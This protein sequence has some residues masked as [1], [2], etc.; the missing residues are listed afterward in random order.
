[1]DLFRQISLKNKI[2]FSTLAV[3]LLLSIVIALLAR[4]SLV[5]SLTDG[6]KQQGLGIAY[7]VAENC[8]RHILTENI[9]EL[10][11]LMFDARQGEESLLIAYVFVVDKENRVLAHSMVT[12]LPNQLPAAN[13][14]AAESF[15]SIKALKIHAATV[16]DIAVPVKEGIYR[17]GT[18]HVGLQKSHID[19]LIGRLR[20]TF[21]GFIAGITILFFWISHL[22][23][24][25]VTRPILQLVRV[26]DEISRGNPDIAPDTDC[27]IRPRFAGD[28]VIQLAN[29]FT[30]MTARL[31]HTEA[32]IRRSEDK[33]RSLFNSGPNPIFVL[34]KET[35]KILDA[36]PNA[37]EFYGYSKSELRD[38]VFS[39]LGT[40]DH[41]RINQMA[42]GDT[43]G[44]IDCVVM[45]KERH[46][47]KEN[48]WFFV[49]LKACPAR[50]RDREV[51]I[52]AATDI[53][54]FIEQE[55][56]LVQASKMTTLG[57]MSAGVAHELNQPLNAIRMGSDY[58]KM[59][60]SENRP[61]PDSDLKELAE[62]MCAQVDRASRIINHLRNFG[63]KPDLAQHPVRFKE[64]I[65]SVLAIIGQQLS[66]Q[67]IEVQLALEDSL[68]PILANRNHL[69]QIFFNLISNARDAII[70]SRATT[71]AARSGVIRIGSFRENDSAV[72]TVTD[73]GT[74]IP[75]D[76]RDRI[77][78]PFF[79]TKDVGK[80]MGLGL[81]IIY[82][83]VR[84][85]GGRI[86][87]ESETGSHTTFK[88]SFPLMVRQ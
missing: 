33:Y 1:M 3:I 57:E 84:D 64:P 77:F 76:I 88:L 29:S 62:A 41:D 80:G 51:I 39:Q 31:K 69:E 23:A 19:A 67:N 40:F 5:S 59:M 52:V 68:P 79:T 66:L 86:D 32:E 22:L 21:L 18:V 75:E 36:N 83:L 16:Y 13:P 30:N 78:E 49:K 65:E 60:V 34:D 72:L 50:Y 25:Q 56:H 12:A 44:P 61:I 82:G 24:K 20:T 42:H 37:E 28:E 87:I 74:G 55:A 9:P 45:E 4:W 54:E 38:M 70:Q 2:F 81:S 35:L 26:A 43:A 58:L 53:T 11:S 15:Y 85:H 10:T 47:N 8:R 48:R 14:I 17:I 27:P 7:A 71:P 46:I 6:L 63:R 73:N